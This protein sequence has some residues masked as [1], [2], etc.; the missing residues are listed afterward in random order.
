M[1]YLKI[2]EVDKRVSMSFL[3]CEGRARRF[4]LQPEDKPVLNDEHAR[5]LLTN[6]SAH[7]PMRNTFLLLINYPISGILLKEPEQ[8]E[9]QFNICAPLSSLR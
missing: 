4:H 6:F 5:V 1:S 8:D 7:S 2:K 3:P 9:T